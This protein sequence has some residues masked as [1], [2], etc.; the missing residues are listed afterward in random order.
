LARVI[1]CDICKQPTSQIVAKM[2]YAEMRKEPIRSK[3]AK[4][5]HNN[6]TKH[7]DV[8]ICCAE[9]VITGFQ[10]RDRMTAAEYHASRSK[11]K[12]GR[13]APTAVEAKQ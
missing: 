8:G 2:F 12:G 6:Y 10:W 1:T 11:S 13:R 9:R 3:N 4:S 7:L 5:I